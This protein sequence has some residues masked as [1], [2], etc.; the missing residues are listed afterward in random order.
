MRA[1]AP[2]YWIFLVGYQPSLKLLR[3][4]WIFKEGAGAEDGGTISVIR[5]ISGLPKARGRGQK[6]ERRTLNFERRT[7]STTISIP[8]PGRAGL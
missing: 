1:Q 3:T 2:G 4:G 6:A 7:K 5:A 8:A